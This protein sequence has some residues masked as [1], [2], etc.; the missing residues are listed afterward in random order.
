MIELKIDETDIE[1]DIDEFQKPLFQSEVDLLTAT[2]MVGNQAEEFRW[3]EDTTAIDTT[4]MDLTTTTL[5]TTTTMTTTSV[6]ENI[7]ELLDEDICW[8]TVQSCGTPF[9][10]LYCSEMCA[11]KKSENQ[12]MT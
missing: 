7:P 5:M 9:M 11:A 1:I 8:N 2:T 10:G 4:V 12:G 3:P 6:V